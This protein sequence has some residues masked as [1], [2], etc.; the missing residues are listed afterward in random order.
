MVI[1]KIIK[2]L[3][4]APHPLFQLRF[5]GVNRWMSRVLSQN[6]AVK[7]AQQTAVLFFYS[8]NVGPMW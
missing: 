4:V 1:R 2:V 8:K 5:L 7:T 3:V 6:F